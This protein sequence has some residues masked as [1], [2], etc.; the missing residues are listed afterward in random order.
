MKDHMLLLK[1]GSLWDQV[2]LNGMYTALSA[3]HFWRKVQRAI[4]KWI[5]KNA[6]VHWKFWSKMILYLSVLWSSGM[7]NWK[8]GCPYIPGSWW[9]LP[10]KTK[11]LNK[12]EIPGRAANLA[13][14]IKAAPDIKSLSRSWTW[15]ES[16]RARQNIW[17]VLQIILESVVT[18]TFV[19][20]GFFCY[21]KKFIFQ[22]V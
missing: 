5:A 19:L 7:N 9:I 14:T 20:S 13:G 22:V 11:E 15:L 18:D 2:I 1:G 16:L 21:L 4:H 17:V 6:G 10:E 8:K 3:E 12:N